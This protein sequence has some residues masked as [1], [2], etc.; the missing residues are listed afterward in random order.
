MST[1]KNKSSKNKQNTFFIACTI[2]AILIVVIFILVKKDEVTAN[3][4][5]TDFFNRAFGKTPEF[6]QNFES[7]SVPEQTNTEKEDVVINLNPPQK[8]DLTQETNSSNS[9]EEKPETSAQEESKNENSN[10]QNVDSAKTENQQN[11]KKQ[12]DENL[13]AKTETS[14]I[15]RY[16]DLKL[17]FV[18]INS[19]GTL[20]RKF[21]NRSVPKTDSP[22]TASIRQLLE[23]PDFTN[24]KEKDC[25]TLIP[26][27]TKLLGAKIQNGI[28]YLDF[29]EN[30]EFNTNGVEG[31]IGQLMQIVYTATE[32]ST[33]NSVQFLIEGEKREFLGSEGL[34]ID[35]PLSKNSF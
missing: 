18:N 31:Y 28:A 21:V 11:T 17:C 7:E 4:K 6:V 22:L 10:S 35:A 25:M 1:K 24:S 20:V 16:T 29:N 26:S 19:D 33:V 32:F 5:E 9:I 34:R 3:L 14:Q 8:S 12:T 2:L 30:F 23:G 15:V 27:G 13:P